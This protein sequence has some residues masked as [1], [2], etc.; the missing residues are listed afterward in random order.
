MLTKNSNDTIGDRTRDLP[1][2]SAMPQLT[3]PPRF[4]SQANGN[5]PDER[6]FYL[7]TVTVYFL[8]AN[9]FSTISAC[10]NVT[11][12]KNNQELPDDCVDARRKASELQLNSD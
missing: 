12:Y 6:H 7:P 3:A 2:C 5:I 4:L 1:A 11:R 10:V 8:W 9:H